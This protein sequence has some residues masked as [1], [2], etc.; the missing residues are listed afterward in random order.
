MKLN[1]WQKLF[2]PILKPA[3]VNWLMNR[4]LV[5]P[6]AKSAVIAKAVGITVDQVVMVQEQLQA[7]AMSQLDAIAK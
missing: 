3:I 6:A 5:V 7:F 4:A 2:W 1:S